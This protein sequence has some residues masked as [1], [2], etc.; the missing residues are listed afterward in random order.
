MT[1][2]RLATLTAIF[3]CSVVIV[4][5]Q[6]QPIYRGGVDVV[7]VNA[8]VRSANKPVGGLAA[9]DF[10]LLDNGVKQTIQTMSIE[11]LPIDVTLLLDVSRSVEGERLTRLTSS[12]IETS[13][14]LRS[15]D[16]LRLISVQ[17]VLREVF[18]WQPG[19]TRPP[20]AGLTAGGGTALYDGVASAIM[21]AAEPDRRQLVIAYTDGLDTISTLSI[22]SLRDL[23]G[24]S[25]AVV[26]FV[27]PTARP[28][29]LNRMSALPTEGALSDLANRTGGQLFLMEYAAPITD[30]FKQAIENFRTSY[31]LRY[32]PTGVK[33]GGWH[34]VTVKVLSGSYEI[35]AR[36]GYS[37]G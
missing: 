20:L 15:T 8:S 31:V 13:Q 23:S 12:V 5:A 7:T 14:L 11:T 2:P 17:H 10:E 22:E 18:P 24:F 33:N 16:R 28:I 1:H 37:G 3:A 32:T 27:V 25:D 30:A 26:Q 34:E 9:A 35:R 29:G 4:G 6:Q 36:K 21:L 19:G